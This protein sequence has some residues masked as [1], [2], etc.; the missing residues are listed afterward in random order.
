MARIP[1][2]DIEQLKQQVS[3]V[4]LV[5]ADGIALTKQGRDYAGRCPF[6]E[7][8]TP[9]LIV[10]PA[11]NLYHCFG[12]NAAGGP[13]DWV[14]HRRGV[15]FRHAV[16]TLRTELGLIDAPVVTAVRTP[17]SFTLAAEADR[18]ALLR[19]VLGYYR[20]TLTQSPDAM[21]YLAK[22][23]LQHPELIARF[24]LGYANRSLGY[25]L[26]DKQLKAGAEQ[27]GRLQTIGL[28]RDSGHE[29][30]N[31]SLVVP[32]IGA[33]GTIHEV[34]GRK[35]R[36]DLR[37]GTAYHLYL[38]G[39]HAGVWNEE[40][41]AACGGE[42]I[43]CEALIDAMTFW[44]H[45][46]KNV[47]ASYGVHGF[48]DDHRAAF[49]R[50][51]IRRVLIAYDRD[52]AGNTAAEA[53][54][55]T[56]MASGIDCYRVL[57][58]KGMDANAYA[59][60]MSP[61][62]KA[63]ALM[64]RKAQWLGNGEAPA[65][66]SARDA[67]EMI[68]PPLVAAPIPP[69]AKEKAVAVEV[70]EPTITSPLPPAPVEDVA[71][72]QGDHDLMLTLG[73]RH[74]RV[75]GWK[76]PLN[77][78]ALKVNLLVSRGERFHVDT[79]DLYQA[80]AR[81]AFTKQAGMELGEAEDVLKHD[82]GRVL[83]KLEAVQ[84]EQLTAA[85]TKE[86]KIPKLSDSEHSEA[87]ALLKS[88]DLLDRI[89]ADFTACGVV[90]ERTNTL[91][92]YV[93]AVSRQLDRPLAVII[94]S[95]S[96]A[97]KSAL[98]DAVLALMPDE[99][100]VR[101]S[102]MTGQSLFYM[103]KTNLKHKIL[104]I[105]E[106]EGASNASYALKL[107]QSEGE[108]TIASTGKDPTT[109]LLVTHEYRVE[110]PVMLFLTTT[111]IDIDEELLNRCLV[112]TVNESREQTRAIHAL[113][114][115][116]Q[117]L[118]G[119]LATTDRDAILAVHRNAQRLLQPLAVVNPHADRL[120]FLDDQTRTRRDHM[121]YLTLIRAIALLHQYQ[122]PVHTVQHRGKELRYIEVV[123]TDIAVANQ[124]A[125]EVLGRTLDELPPQTRLLL[126][127][128]HTWVTDECERLAVS[129]TDLRF[130]RRQV[131]ALT[132][133]GDTQLKIHLG[134]LAELEYV[135]IHRADRG[136][137]FDYELLYDG[138]GEHGGR[139]LMGLTEANGVA[140]TAYDDDRSGVSAARSVPG[141]ATVGPVSGRGRRVAEAVHTLH[142]NVSTL[143]DAKT[144]PKS[145]A[146]VV[147]RSGSYAAASHLAAGK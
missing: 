53:L 6:H 11:K 94:Q 137:R 27:R 100:Q 131:R 8:A 2:H 75:R 128:V 79:L 29:H 47:T 82:L 60:A 89:V 96:A 17:A 105:A 85:L 66:T 20:E 25:R 65:L 64:I 24:Q 63:L 134:R 110:G 97:G 58:P 52:D 86:D 61:P 1:E 31:G 123:P 57:F 80:K 50:Y 68:D 113:Q 77:P 116:R 33:D 140:M 41:L 115:R 93:A 124:L 30:F 23:G 90:G 74:Y 101:Y 54:A 142:D 132:G 16:E 5:E 114:R 95:S 138:E 127:H 103:G 45:G 7:D 129:R 59:L 139:F 91:V 98:M 130:T 145:T 4:R 26:P 46:L 19:Q 22:R 70:P 117:T 48:T 36:D 81:A 72:P 125:H 42:V 13:I 56:L 28:L 143:I 102:A 118:D 109:G 18:Q 92:G 112:L 69:A 55:K 107:L 78:E 34:Y 99:D 122:R 12:C 136:Q 104:A 10:T 35:I 14:M 88:P 71:T 38:P 40:G 51:G 87:L 147:S 3:L 67:R 49:A 126:K 62:A 43:L 39:P 21:A 111:A 76:K 73:D 120:T 15:S 37:A 133:W 83:L 106:E 146:P 44:V 119:L 141:R 135:L 84:T 144:L 108:V 121:K 32:V 9:S